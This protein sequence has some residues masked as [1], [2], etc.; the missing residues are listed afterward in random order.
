MT[1][2][3]VL[4]SRLGGKGSVKVVEEPCNV[5]LVIT[6][7]IAEDEVF[8]ALDLV[9]A[10]EEDRQ[11]KRGQEGK[12]NRLRW[13]GR[14]RREVLCGEGLVEVAGP[15]QGVGGRVGPELE[16][17]KVVAMQNDRHLLDDDPG[18]GPEVHLSDDPGFIGRRQHVAP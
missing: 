10:P 12:V 9:L 18:H 16:G 17:W 8:E 4:I 1:T 5:V 13:I 6:A 7:R 2:R 11:F 14:W 15:F 3:L